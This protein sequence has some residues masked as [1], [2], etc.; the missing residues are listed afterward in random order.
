V[1]YGGHTAGLFSIL[2]G[3]GATAA[4]SPPVVIGIGG[5]LA[6][7]GI[8]FLSPGQQDVKL[9]IEFLNVWN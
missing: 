7:A 3:I 2:Q 1:V 9:S 5:T 8:Y 4:V 6:G